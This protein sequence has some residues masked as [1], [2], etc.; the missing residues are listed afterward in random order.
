MANI[1]WS[2]VE[3]WKYNLTASWYV[4]TQYGNDFD[5]DGVGLYE[6]SSNPNGH[7][8]KTRPFATIDKLILSNLSG[9]IV[10]DSGNYI[11]LLAIERV[12]FIADGNVVITGLTVYIGSFFGCVCVN[13]KQYS[14]SGLWCFNSCKVINSTVEYYTIKADNSILVKVTTSNYAA[15]FMV[16]N[17]CLIDCNG[18]IITQ[19]IY[20]GIF[21]VCNNI[22]INCRLY[23]NIV[24][25]STIIGYNLYINTSI[26][27]DKPNLSLL[28]KSLTEIE[29]FNNPSGTGATVEQLQTIFNNYFYPILPD[30]LPFLDL[31][32]KPTASKK[33]KYGGMNGYYIGALP[34]G[35]SFGAAELWNNRNASQTSGLQ[36]DTDE[37]IY[38][39]DG[40]TSGTFTSNIITLEKPVIIEAVNFFNNLLYNENNIAALRVDTTPDDAPSNTTNQRTVYDYR[41]RY[42]AV[43]GTPLSEYKNFE[44]NRTPYIDALQNSCL[45]DSYTE[46]DRNMITVQDFVIEFTMRKL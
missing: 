13:L 37:G 25:S 43:A 28:N 40:A 41:L 21:N 19:N 46:A 12:Y 31:S 27:N 39:L 4:S 36:F 3:K 2:G 32:L 6:P 26:A 10:L 30:D 5:V 35:Y 38:L 33:I 9:N 14:S 7:G 42:A 24:E 29:L 11:S 1:K 45:A 17:C 44:L 8:G 34:I 22:L 20:I 23:Y 15:G 18:Y 16:N